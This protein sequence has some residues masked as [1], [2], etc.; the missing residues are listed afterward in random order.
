MSTLTTRAGK[1]SPLTNTEVDNNFTNLNT[2]KYEAS[3]DIS[4]G[5]VTYTGNFVAGMNASVTAAGTVQGDATALTK[6]YNL[7]QSASANQGVKLPDAAAG[8]KVTVY[9]STANDIKIYPATS[10]SIDGGS[11]NAPVVLRPGNVFDAIATGATSWE[12]ITA[13][14]TDLD[15]TSVTTSGDLTVGGFEQSGV[16]AALSSAGSSQGDAT[17]I[18]ETITVVTT[19]SA[20]TTGVKLPV[21]V[22]GRTVSVFNSTSTD[23]KLYPNSSDTIN[24]GS[25]NAAIT[26]PA[27]T[28][29]TLSCK[30]ATDWRVHRPLAVYDSSGTLL[31]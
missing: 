1:G 19:V 17:Q 21:A 6:T 20:D 11:L 8:L 29:Y 12:Q 15:V 23:C 5:A 4:V 27:N 30:D 9:N 24:G 13:D 14:L 7:V 22:A 26:L 3:D 31:N 16:T 2:D 10:E 18:A 25:A 28:S